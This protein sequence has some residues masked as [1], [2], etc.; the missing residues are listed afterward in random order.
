[1]RMDVRITAVGSDLATGY[2]DLLAWLNGD[3]DLRC[4]VRVLSSQPVSAQLG[5]AIESIAVSLGS[6]GV[7]VALTRVLADFV[8]NRRSDISV[9]VTRGEKTV[10][11]DAKRV[12][13]A[14]ALLQEV[15][16]D[17]GE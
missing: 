10:T 1:M 6:S 15:L 16:R 9:T 13:E 12:A 14:K 3:R 7:G 4:N 8:R 2:A 11:V 5:G 17:S